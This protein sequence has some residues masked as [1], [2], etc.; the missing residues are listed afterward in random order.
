MFSVS[1]S[2]MME[3]KVLNLHR[4]MAIPRPVMPYLVNSG[5]SRKRE[6]AKLHYM[7]NYLVGTCA[8]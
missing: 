3:L 5:R 6:Y 2:K 7:G 8:L 1:E 4:L